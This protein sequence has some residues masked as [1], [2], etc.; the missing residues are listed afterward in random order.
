MEFFES[1]IFTKR[2]PGLLTDDD[3]RLVQEVLTSNPFVG[4]L[5]RGGHGLRKMRWAS[6]LGNRGKS[7]GIRVIY[8]VASDR[9]YLLTAYAKKKQGTVEGSELEALS[10]LVKKESV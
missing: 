8:Y 2:L 10:K 4:R 1:S 6:S 7:S 5:I 3:Y 9:I